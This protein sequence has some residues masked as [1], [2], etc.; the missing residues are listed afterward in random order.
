M[1]TNMDHLNIVKHEIDSQELS[2]IDIKVEY[3]PVEQ[4]PHQNC[5][6]P[7]M[8]NYNSS[9]IKE[10]LMLSWNPSSSAHEKVNE[11]SILTMNR[12]VQDS[13]INA[14]I[15]RKIFL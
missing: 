1:P 5:M 6:E 8:S 3:H 13:T 11:K 7:G 15:V 12:S 14:I 10:E 9:S 2:N 4:E